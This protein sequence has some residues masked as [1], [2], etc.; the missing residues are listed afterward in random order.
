MT[1]TIMRDSIVGDAWIMQTCQAVPIQ[2]V[3]NDK[4]EV[5]QDILTGPV[6]L[7]WCDLFELPPVTK[8]NQNPKYGTTLLFPPNNLIDMTLFYEDYYKVCAAS[9]AD[10]WDGGTQQY[11]G[12]K[13]P[14]RPQEEKL[15]FQGYTPGSIFMT[16][17]TKFK[18][19]VV[20]VR[21][22]PIVDP[23]KVYP[24]VWAICSVNAYPNTDARTK[25][26]RF[27]LQ[28]VMI[29]GDDKSLGGG[30]ADPSQ[31]FKG[32]AGQVAAP[33]VRPDIARNMPGSAPA[34]GG[35]PAGAP[36]IPQSH[37]SA[38]GASPPPP[39][40]VSAPESEDDRMMREMLGG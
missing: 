17:S 23:S 7:S 37:Y 3:L 19:S 15:K 16:V 20:D 2:R 36:P 38:P 40:P 33:I 1:T 6:R 28:N 39:P 10:H 26:V 12:L 32:I 4:G 21:G 27:G 29:I 22:N 18:P 9:F 13:T 35:V 25:G 34:P 8:D 31:T 24:G 14:F 30:G 11:Y 5:T